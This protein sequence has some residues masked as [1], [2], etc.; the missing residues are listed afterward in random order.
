MK[1]KTALI[2]CDIKN[3]VICQRERKKNKNGK[4]V[5]AWA[6]KMRQKWPSKRT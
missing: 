6:C 4:V 2:S 5:P 1:N 3:Y